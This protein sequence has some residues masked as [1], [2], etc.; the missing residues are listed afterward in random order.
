MPDETVLVDT[1]VR[2]VKAL[3]STLHLLERDR[4]GWTMLQSCVQLR[5]CGSLREF[6]ILESKRMSESYS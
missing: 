2:T 3:V 5:C 1:L 6:T 4:F